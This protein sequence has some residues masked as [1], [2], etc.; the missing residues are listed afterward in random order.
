VAELDG[1]LTLAEFLAP[2]PEAAK[3]LTH[4]ST[5]IDW[6]AQHPGR[7]PFVYVDGKHAADVVRQEAALIRDRQEAGDVTVF[8]DV[9]IPAVAQALETLDGYLRE[10]VQPTRDRKYV[11]ARRL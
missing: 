5:G 1:L 3:I 6:L 9:Q 2:W 7:L 11:I 4:Q 10:D 8:D